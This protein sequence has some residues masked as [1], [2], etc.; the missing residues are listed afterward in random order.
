MR[1][2]VKHYPD[3]LKLEVIKEYLS[4]DKSQRE[5]M[6]KYKIGGINTIKNW[7]RKFDLEE[8]REE[9]IKTQRIMAKELGKTAKERELEVKVARLEQELEYER[10]RTLALNTLINVAERDLKITIRKKP[11]AKR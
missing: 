11:G 7:M 1:Q 3:E 10:F 5:L 8:P 4:T 6:L 2:K 9:Q